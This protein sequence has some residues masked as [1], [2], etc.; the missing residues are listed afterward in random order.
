M[1]CCVDF[2]RNPLVRLIL[3]ESWHPGG[4]ELTRRLARHFHGRVLDVACGSGVSVELLRREFGLRAVG[5]DARREG[6]SLRGR[7]GRLP[8]RDGSFDGVLVECALST[9]EDQERALAEIRRVL[10]PGG[11]LAISDMTVE[12]PLPA[13][14]D[15]AIA[16]VACLVRARS[17][18]G[19]GTLL[20]S[21]G[22]FEVRTEDRSSDLDSLLLSVEEKVEA[23]RIFGVPVEEVRRHLA[24][25]RA[26]T[27]EG[28]LGYA[29]MVASRS[30]PAVSADASA[31][32]TDRR[33]TSGIPRSRPTE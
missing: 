18:E 26:L 25:A 2:Y 17:R 3:G 4:L 30:G 28:R 8:F 19:W 21:A 6:V 24:T 9:F 22:F 15:G 32:S 1:N 29:A 20:R 31:T 7:A 14:F 11:T 23:V 27:Q 12:G 5:L 33:R 16:T 10:A 13:E